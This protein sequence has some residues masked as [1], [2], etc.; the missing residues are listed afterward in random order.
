MVETMTT[1]EDRE[2][3]QLRQTWVIS[4]LYDAACGIRVTA[5][6]QSLGTLHGIS[7]CPE[8]LNVLRIK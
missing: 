3:S 4:L 2:T 5:P 1:V 7:K 8:R 6:V